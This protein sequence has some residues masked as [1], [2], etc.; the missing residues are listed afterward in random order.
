MLSEERKL[1]ICEF[2]NQQ[3]AVTVQELMNE[4]CTSEATIRRD[5]TE[6]DKKGLLLKVHG[7]AVALQKQITTDFK[8][9]ERETV[10]REEKITI[11]RYA[12]SLIQGSD[13]V[14]L[15]AGTTT[16][17][18]IDYLD[19]DMCRETVFVTNAIV[20]AKK[21]STGGYTVYLTGG[22]VKATTEALIGSECHAS[23]QKYHFSIGFFGA[24]A[25]SRTAGI[26]T[27]DPEEAEIKRTAMLRT[28]VPYVLC[29]HEKFDKTSSVRF[30]DFS[31]GKI[32]TTNL[33]PLAYREEETII[34]V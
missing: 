26:T 28:R 31:Y 25:V 8:V 6:L 32:I 22:K 5:L 2:V 24:N 7:G 18:L 9:A 23:L 1:H 21:L 15:D 33:I 3:N 34:I 29:D 4:F 27:P 19:Y 17:L 20:H 10:N 14:Y 12:A 16:S 11:A 30:A 13:L